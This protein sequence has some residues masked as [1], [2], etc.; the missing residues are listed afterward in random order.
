M[1][2][3]A[4]VPAS[5]S[6][7]HPV[8]QEWFVQKF[9]T[10]TEPQ[11]QGWPHILAG[12]TVLISAPTGS[13][14]TLA[15]FLACIDRLVRQAIAGELRD[16][17]EVVYISPLKALGNDIQKNLEAPLAEIAQLALERGYLMPGIRTFVRSGDTPAADRQRMLKKPPHIL[18]TTPE[19]LYILLTSEKSRGL[20]KS[21]KTVIV[22]EIHA[23][24]DDKRGAH[25]AISLER[26]DALVTAENDPLFRGI[27]D[28]PNRIGLSA[29]QKPIELVAQYLTGAH[30]DRAPAKIVNIGHRREID[31]AVE[32]PQSELGA[33]TTMQMW[34][35][36]N[37]RLCELIESHRSPLIFVNTRGM[38]E[39]LAH[40]LNERLTPEKSEP[41]VLSHHGS[42]SRKIRLNAENKLKRGEIKALVATASLEL[43]IDVGFIDLV[44]QIGTCRSIAVMLQ[45]I[46]RAGHWRGA[47]PKGRLFATTRDEVIECAAIARAIQHGDLDELE[48]PH[49]PL[50]ILAQQI[51]AMCAAELD[52]WHEDELLALIRRAHPYRELTDSDYQDVLKMLAEGFT[53]KRGRY[54]AYLQRDGVHQRLRARRGSR[55]VAVTNG[56]AIPDNA[57]FTVIS[58][59][60][61]AMVATLDEDFAIDSSPGDVILLGNTSWR[62]RRIESR[63]RVLV[64][65][66]HG[67]PP[68]VPFWR[69]EAPQRTRELSRHVGEIR[70]TVSDLTP[71]LA[72]GFINEQR[73][74]AQARASVEW[75][76]RECAVSESAAEQITDYIVTGRAVLGGVPTQNAIY[77]ERFFD[78]GGGMQL[79]IHAPFGGRVL[80]AFALALRKKFCKSFNFELQA[81]ATDNALNIALAEQHSFVLSD[82]FHYVVDESAQHT[83]EQAS[84]DSPI[85]AA[86]WRWNAGRALAL[87]RYRG[88]KKVA[89]Q[90]Q[91]IQSDDLL[92]SVFPDLAAC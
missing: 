15:A 56:G 13:G 29:T 3:V 92:A 57:L 40:S 59:P 79:V 12:E 73:R 30:P 53:A 85:F 47:I 68:T 63:G 5:L 26:L 69:G 39:R 89:P 58:E 61:G 7:A 80:K 44:A 77:A 25:L 60:E 37:Q 35:E 20:L 36:I 52:G 1:S 38:A 82:V 43:G 2:A 34:D 32:I 86:R 87:L 78:D 16:Q 71:S 74:H 70:Q 46:G 27:Q 81:S 28:A 24:A 91:R 6:W 23:M 75:L 17:I 54:G 83:L 19:S 10:P 48:I 21:V 14:K 41:C 31:F 42:L 50:D 62:V 49:A 55:L 4:A 76:M 45:R 51:V 90:I 11:E 8:V 64:E 66:A 67:A 88:G 65:D 22:D 72:P 18:V 9:G 33:V 84:L